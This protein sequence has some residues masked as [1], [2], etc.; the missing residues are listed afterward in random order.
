MKPTDEQVKALRR[1]IA[2]RRVHWLSFSLALPT[3]MI[4][5]GA[6][7]KPGWWPYVIPLVLTLC[8][9]AFS[10]YRVNRARCPRCGHLFFFIQKGPLGAMGTSFPLQKRCAHC[11]MAI[12]R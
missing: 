8:L 5:I 3:A 10:W 9:Y 6:F 12:R 4:F 7:Q 2:W 1:I 11:G